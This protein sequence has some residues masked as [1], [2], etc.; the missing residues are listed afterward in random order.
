MK[1]LI[2]IVLCTLMLVASTA[3]V[4]GMSAGLEQTI[5]GDVL[6]KLS[7]VLSDDQQSA[8]DQDSPVVSG[9]E[10]EMWGVYPFFPQEH[11]WTDGE[12]IYFASAKT[13]M[14]YLFK[15]DGA[16]TKL[17]N[18]MPVEL[19]FEERPV[20]AVDFEAMYVRNGYLF[21]VVTCEHNRNDQNYKE[22][23]EKYSWPDVTYLQVYSL[24]DHTGFRHVNTLEQSGSLY[25]CCMEGSSLIFITEAGNEW[26]KKPGL[27]GTL[28][29]EIF[30]S[31]N[32]KKTSIGAEE[33]ELNLD[34][35]TIIV[36]A[37]DTEDV[38]NITLRQVIMGNHDQLDAWI[39]L[40]CQNAMEKVGNEEYMQD[41][42]VSDLGLV[43]SWELIP[44]DYTGSTSEYVDVYYEIELDIPH[45]LVDQDVPF[46]G[47][48]D[49][50][51]SDWSG[52]R[53]GDL[54]ILQSN[55]Y[56]DYLLIVSAETLEPV[57][58]VS[59]N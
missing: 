16:N 18:K 1:K 55:C 3:C 10:E 17:V 46:I 49:M 52:Y 50:I 34:P 57:T 19:P 26:I 28:K 5:S 12:W 51:P 45:V 24:D 30:F 37:I 32:G 6:N 4:K 13:K 7:E 15:L 25:T 53:V 43:R 36:T 42:M 8:Q 58:I 21:L 2:A 29:N 35:A 56:T 48:T 39:E 59:F 33:I 54:L 22:N 23:A 40:F 44:T 14:L 41:H 47:G 20:D 9:D 31:I 38:S 11:M 27:D